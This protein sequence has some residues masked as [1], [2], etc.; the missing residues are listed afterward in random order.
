M[1]APRVPVASRLAHMTLSSTLKVLQA[2]E[3]LKAEGVDVISLGA[4]EP[5]VPTPENIKAA[6][7]TAIE[8]GFT[9]YTPTAGTA[10]LK[11]TIIERMR[12]DFDADYTP[13]EVIATVGGK[14]GIFEAVA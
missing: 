9:R 1:T 10:D 14:Q 13:E 5:D 11:R 6:G 7:K 12:R 4:G 8:A 3:R 2:T